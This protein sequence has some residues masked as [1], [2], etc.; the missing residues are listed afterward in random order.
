MRGPRSWSPRSASH[1]PCSARIALQDRGVIDQVVGR[2][3][4][5]NSP[6]ESQTRPAGLSALE[7]LVALGGE[8]SPLGLVRASDAVD[9]ATSSPGVPRRRCR[10]RSPIGALHGSE[11]ER[12]SVLERVNGDPVAEDVPLDREQERRARRREAL[13]ERRSDEA[14]E[15]AAPA[16]HLLDGIHV[17]RREAVPRRTRR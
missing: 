7:V 10:R 14:M 15:I 13:E 8:L 16:S 3:S 12:Q 11:R 9:S 5:S 2:A 1:S 4:S 17:G 6:G